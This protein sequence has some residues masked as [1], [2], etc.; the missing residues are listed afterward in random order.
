MMRENLIGTECFLTKR[1]C[2]WFRICVN[3]KMSPQASSINIRLVTP[4]TW[5]WRYVLMI[6][7]NMFL[8]TEFGSKLLHTSCTHKI[9][10]WR[11]RSTCILLWST[12]VFMKVLTKVC[13]I[14]KRLV[15]QGTGELFY[16]LFYCF[17]L[18]RFIFYQSTR[19]WH[20]LYY[21]CMIV[22]WWIGDVFSWDI[23]DIIGESFKFWRVFF[24][25]QLNLKACKV[26]WDNLLLWWFQ[27]SRV[28]SHLNQFK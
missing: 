26:W 1:T 14:S 27:F 28:N 4:C 3:L 6:N 10:R 13:F 21:Y 22:N 19:F 8:K 9:G 5:K 20:W 2:K 12:E 25:L 15:T 16:I 7:T 17:L 11:S 23:T 24:S 18:F